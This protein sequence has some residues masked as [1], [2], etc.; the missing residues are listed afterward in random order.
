MTP[1]E[2]AKKHG[3]EVASE[4]EGDVRDIS[5]IYC[6]DLLSMVM[7]RAKEDNALITIMGNVN[8]VAV[9]VLA[10]VS[11]V[12]LCEGIRLDDACLKKAKD[13][14]VCVLYSQQSNFDTALKLAK[15]LGL[16][17]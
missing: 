1:I 12:I 7:G 11:C 6:C 5:G 14:A 13:Q 2:F 8:T 10:D 9:G 16:C 17:S 4:G 3:L 15:E